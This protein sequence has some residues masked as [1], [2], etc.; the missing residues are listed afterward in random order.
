MWLC[1]HSWKLVAET[2]TKSVLEHT[3]E[4]TAKYDK[5]FSSLPPQLSKGSRKF[6]QILQC[7]K[8]GKL[9]RFV[10]NI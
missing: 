4:Q 2:T 10:D 7:E 1:K 5:H 8:C 9:N 6:I 3:L